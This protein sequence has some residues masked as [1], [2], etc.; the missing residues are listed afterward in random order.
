MNDQTRQTKFQAIDE[1]EIEDF[2]T[3]VKAQGLHS[4]AYD[5][6]E[7]VEETEAAATHGLVF[8]RARAIVTCKKIGASR[9]YAAGDDGTA[10]VIHFEQDL[11]AG[12]FR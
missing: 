11:L 9:Y 7:E 5:L 4:D 6:A 12:H 10:W 2:R 8:R 1:T 3:V